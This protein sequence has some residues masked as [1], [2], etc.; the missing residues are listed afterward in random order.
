[1]IFIAKT[2]LCTEVPCTC[3]GENEMKDACILHSIAAVYSKVL[4][5]CS[6]SVKYTEHYKISLTVHHEPKVQMS[7]IVNK[8]QR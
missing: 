5:F 6:H 1:M 4:S 3:I 7:C 2:F 8:V